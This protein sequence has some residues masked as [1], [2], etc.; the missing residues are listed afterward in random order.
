LRLEYV[1]Q[2]IA[3]VL[4][5]RESI[6][7]GFS[8]VQTP[9][10]HRD[11]YQVPN[12]DELLV[13]AGRRV[14]SKKLPTTKSDHGYKDCV[15]W[16]CILRLERGTE[17]RFISR[18]KAFFTQ[19]A[20]SP[21]LASEADAP[22]IHVVASMDLEPVLRELQSQGSPGFA[23]ELVARPQRERSVHRNR[24]VTGCPLLANPA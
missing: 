15:I 14:I 19:G 20:R 9:V 13:A 17:V 16:E 24:S 7:D 10:G 11:D 23:R 12:D 6:D 18:D 3:A 2:T 8:R 22:G 21:E 5:A 4:E 1:E